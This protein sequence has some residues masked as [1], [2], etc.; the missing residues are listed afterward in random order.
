MVL[1][2]DKPVPIWGWA[3]KG[4]TV[5]VSFAGQAQSA[6]A[7]DDGRWIDTL[8][9]L[10]ASAAGRTMKIAA[11]GRTI[12]LDDILVGD[13]WLCSGQS[14]MAAAMG[15]VGYVPPSRRR[16]GR[17]SGAP[18]GIPDGFDPSRY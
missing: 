14:N 13:V 18:K 10:E 1:Q 5:T 8:E 7:G 16:P 3:P 4:T 11:G 17:G 12:V 6:T 9:P 2:R 15:Q